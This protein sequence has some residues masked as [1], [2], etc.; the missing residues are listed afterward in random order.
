[1][2]SVIQAAPGGQGTG[3]A[4]STLAATSTAG[5]TLVAIAVIIQDGAASTFNTPSGW[6]TL[7]SELDIGINGPKAQAYIYQSAPA[8]DSV[9]VTC[10]DAA[11]EMLVKLFELPATAT[12]ALANEAGNSL[13]A[14]TLSAGPVSS[15]V[16]DAVAIGVTAHRN[17]GDTQGSFTGDFT[18]LETLATT[19][20]QAWNDGVAAWHS[21]D[22]SSVQDLSLG[23]NV[24]PGGGNRNMIVKF[25]VVEMQATTDTFSSVGSPLATATVSS[26]DVTPPTVTISDPTDT[27]PAT[28]YQ[29]VRGTITLSCVATDDTAVTG[30]DFYYN[31]GAGDVLI[32]SA[33][34]TSGDT[35]EI[36]FD[37]LTLANQ[38]GVTFKA[39]ATDGASNSASDSV[40]VVINNSGWWRGGSPP[41]P[42]TWSR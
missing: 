3:S 20:G 22:I 9:T 25:V 5:N 32:G 33:A 1:M 23:F 14:Q 10:S 7:G 15:N 8:T 27:A 31:I 17:T 29:H 37:T 6:S 2:G 11:D 38:R 40:V 36:N 41:Q 30:V 13:Y 24:S 28:D 42:L 18:H 39:T 21:A 16:A 34:N 26:S 35:W 19:S 4:T 12:P